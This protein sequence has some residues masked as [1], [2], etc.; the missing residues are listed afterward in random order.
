MKGD[1]GTCITVYVND[2]ITATSKTV[3]CKSVHCLLLDLGIGQHHLVLIN[4]LNPP[5]VDNR[6]NLLTA[7]VTGS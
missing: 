6:D 7:H 4:A 2:N 5:S 1:G 3:A